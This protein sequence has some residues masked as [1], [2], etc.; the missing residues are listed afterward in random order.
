MF[1]TAQLIVQVVVLSQIYQKIHFIER[2]SLFGSF[3]SLNIFFKLTNA[4]I[5]TLSIS[6]SAV[7]DE[8]DVIKEKNKKAVAVQFTSLRYSTFL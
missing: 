7:V 5:Y 2:I 4:S 3:G 8:N 1:G 6:L